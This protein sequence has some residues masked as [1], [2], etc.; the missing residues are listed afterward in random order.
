MRKLLLLCIALSATAVLG[1]DRPRPP[2]VSHEI[3]SEL[4]DYKSR[5]DMLAKAVKR[6][7]YIV[8][9]MVHATGDLRDF[10][11]N[12]AIEKAI[13][14]LTSAQLRANEV[15]QASP[16]TMT[17]LSKID[18]ALHHARQQASSADLPA[19]AET[20]LKESHDIQLDLFR[21]VE[22][23]RREREMLAELQKKL[24]ETN[25]DLEAAMIE[26]LGSTMNFIRAGGK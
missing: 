1:Q 7:A 15:P 6:D 14:R 2:Q 21:N 17:A 18:D 10:Q 16:Q 5:L 11:R 12:A 9:Q 4:S 13:D 24:S 23:A 22:T 26:A 25:L 3:A 19:L 8:A 20:I